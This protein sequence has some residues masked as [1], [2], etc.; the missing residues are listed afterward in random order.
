MRA[1]IDPDLKAEVEHLF[2]E[3]GITTKE[4]IT[5]FYSQVKLRKGLPFDVPIPNKDNLNKFSKIPMLVET[6]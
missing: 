3:L 5:L 1:K 6:L 4:A 2:K